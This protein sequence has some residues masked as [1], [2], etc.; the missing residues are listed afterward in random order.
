MSRY[1]IFFF[2]YFFFRA[3][4]YRCNEDNDCVHSSCKSDLA[5]ANAKLVRTHHAFRVNCS[6]GYF[7]QSQA[8]RKKLK[9]EVSSNFSTRFFLFSIK[10]LF[11]KL[12]CENRWLF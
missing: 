12:F 1:S 11:S 8:E 3:L 2:L 9:P 6:Q 10:P 5:D 4:E 7:V